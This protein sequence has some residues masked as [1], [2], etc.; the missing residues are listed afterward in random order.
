[1]KHSVLASRIARLEARN[2]PRRLPR[3]CFMIHAEDAPSELEGFRLPDGSIV[4]PNPGEALSAARARAWQG[5]GSG[6]AMWAVYAP[7][8]EPTSIVPPALV[9]AAPAKPDPN[10]LAGIGIVGRGWKK[11]PD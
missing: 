9:A 10:A 6:Q 8:S 3:L 7:S 5:L 11:F 4:P 2:C 1:M